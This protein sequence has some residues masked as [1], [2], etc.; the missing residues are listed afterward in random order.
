[1]YEWA[2]CRADDYF[3]GESSAL[4]L[5]RDVR[6]HTP[7]MPAVLELAIGD[8]E[9]WAHMADA[10]FQQ[11]GQALDY[12]TRRLPDG[13]L[14]E[15]ERH[16]LRLLAKY[17]GAL[18]QGLL[19]ELGAAVLALQRGDGG[20]HRRVMAAALQRLASARLVRLSRRRRG[21]DD[22]AREVY[23]PAPVL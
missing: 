4:L 5:D 21:A 13:L 19:C 1:M 2:G 10:E 14:S 15:P 22:D 18:P 16:V 11:P 3:A 6:K 12:V 9:L 20:P 23:L 17:G 8:R 7:V